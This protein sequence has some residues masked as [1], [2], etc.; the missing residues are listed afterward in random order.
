GIAAVQQERQKDGQP[1]LEKGLDVF[2]TT[3]E[4]RRVLRL[5]WNR[6]ERL[7][8]Q[9]EV[10]S[11]R[12]EESQRQGQDARGAAVAARGAWKQ[13][14]AAFAQYERSEAGWKIA[15]GALSVFRPDGQ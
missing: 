10:A 11:R 14:E 8:E 9:A 4:A 3:Y 2:H 5:S 1:P 15:H 12:V 13:T 6:V 7:W